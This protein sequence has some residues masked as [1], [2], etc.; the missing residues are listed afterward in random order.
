M[1]ARRAPAFSTR[2][3]KSYPTPRRIEEMPFAVPTKAGPWIA[4]ATSGTFAAVGILAALYHRDMTGEGQAIDVATPEAYE[5]LNDYALHWY[6]DQGVIN[7]ERFG[8]LDCCPV[9]LWFLP[10]K[11]RRSLPRR[12]CAWRCGRPWWICWG[13]WD[14]WGA[15][16]WKTLAPFMQ[17]DWQLKYQSMINSLDFTVYERGTDPKI[18]RISKS[19]RLA[20]I[21]PVV[22]EIVSP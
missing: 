17:K 7:F 22:A 4:W 21:T 10:D 14:E 8:N 6:G 19:G 2:Q 13:R 11:G 1:S 18:D 12:A 5:R 16:S 15:E 20:P 3:E 9:A